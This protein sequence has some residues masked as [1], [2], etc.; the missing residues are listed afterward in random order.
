MTQRVLL[1]ILGSSSQRL[2]K[3]HICSLVFASFLQYTITLLNFDT[4]YDTSL[5]PYNGL[6]HT[7]VGLGD[8]ISKT[9]T[10]LGLFE[11]V[12]A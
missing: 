10:K 3:G 6:R 11:F 4:H 1:L 5:V 12:A 7:L 8:K 9:K 2:T